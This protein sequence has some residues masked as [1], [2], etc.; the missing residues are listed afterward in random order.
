VHVFD[1]CKFQ[2]RP[3]S[4]ICKATSFEVIE[5]I[6]ITTKKQVEIDYADVSPHVEAIT[7]QRIKLSMFLHH[8]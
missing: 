4:L 8:D 7:L 2:K 5:E 6:G 1:E 3:V